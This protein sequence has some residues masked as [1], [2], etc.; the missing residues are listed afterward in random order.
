M[1]YLIY[2]SHQCYGVGSIFIPISHMGPGEAWELI[3]G[4]TVCKRQ[5]WDFNPGSPVLESGQ[6]LFWTTLNSHSTAS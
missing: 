5:G 6:P 3:E 4:L 2:H 1:Y